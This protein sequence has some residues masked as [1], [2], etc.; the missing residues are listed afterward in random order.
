MYTERSATP[1]R[2]GLERFTRSIAG[3]LITNER[4]ESVTDPETGEER[5]EY[6]Y[7]VYDVP[8]ARSPRAAKNVAIDEAH[9]N[10]DEHKILRKTLARVL[11]STGQ[12]DAEEHAEFRAYNEL[13]ERIR[14]EGAQ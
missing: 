12:Y 13:C 4:M 2:L 7:D 1:M 6:V 5:T 9:P 3:R 14:P 10:G 8:D 11:R